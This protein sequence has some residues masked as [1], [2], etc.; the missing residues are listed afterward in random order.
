M[1][2]DINWNYSYSTTNKYQYSVER[3]TNTPPLESS[4]RQLLC[5]TCG[6]Q[7]YS[8]AKMAHHMQFHAESNRQTYSDDED[9]LETIPL[10]TILEEEHDV[11][12]SIG[13]RMRDYLWHKHASKLLSKKLSHCGLCR[14]KYHYRRASLARHFLT[15]HAGKSHKCSFCGCRFRHKYQMKWHN[16]CERNFRHS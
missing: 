13:S 3:P 12:V 11:K 16:S 4:P 10:Q 9:E 7:T 6:M 15:N 5:I 1:R 8:K 2:Q 14:S